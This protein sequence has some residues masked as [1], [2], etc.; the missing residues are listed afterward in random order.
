[1]SRSPCADCP[2]KG[3]GVYHDTCPEYQEWVKP[4]RAEY[5]RRNQDGQ[6]KT[7]TFEAMKRMKRS[8]SKFE[9]NKNPAKEFLSQYQGIQKECAALERTIQAQFEKAT[10]TTVA[11]G[12]MA[13][14]NY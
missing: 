7:Y 2:R 14:R 9:R 4:F 6:L 10:N 1:M 11:F 12:N 8:K 13:G 5:R 3:C